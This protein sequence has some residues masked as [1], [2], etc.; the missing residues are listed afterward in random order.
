MLFYGCFSLLLLNGRF[1]KRYNFLSYSVDFHT[2]FALFL[3][4]IFITI[5]VIG[6]EIFVLIRKRKKKQRSTHYLIW[7]RDY[8]NEVWSMIIQKRTERVLLQKQ[9]IYKILQPH[10]IIFTSITLWA[11]K[12]DKGSDSCFFSFLL[13]CLFRKNHRE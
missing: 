4:F 1:I 5:N 13:L 2:P 6:H 12:I 10:K 9:V 8:K 7:N 3:I 11:H